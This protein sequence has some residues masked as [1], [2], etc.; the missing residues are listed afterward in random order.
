MKSLVAL[1]MRGFLMADASA[2]TAGSAR[3]RARRRPHRDFS[4]ERLED[5]TLMSANAAGWSEKPVAPPVPVAA[6]V[7]HTAVAQVA[8][9][10][11]VARPGATARNVAATRAT[12]TVPDV[13]D[14]GQ[15]AVFTVKLSQPAGPRGAS[16]AYT[17]RD[18]R[19]RAGVDYTATRGTVTFR[20]GETEKTVSVPT[21]AS[22]PV[23]AKAVNF[24]LVL[25]SASNA[26]ITVNTATTRI[27]DPL[28]VVPPP[29]FTI[30]VTFPDNSL[31]L[32]QQRVF[33]VAA[34]RWSEIITGDL[35]D[36]TWD[37]RTI[38]DIEIAA[39]AP[40]ID[41]VGS[42]LGQAAWS[43]LRPIPAGTPANAPNTQLPFL[44]FMRFDSADVSM[45]MGNGTF[46]SVVLHEMGHVLGI[47]SSLWSVKRLVTGLGTTN[48]VYTGPKALAEYNKLLSIPTATSVPLEN[49]GGGGTA[50]SHWRESIFDTELMTGYSEQGGIPMPISRVTVGAL[51]DLGYT[52]DYAKA[53]PFRLRANV[54]GT[55]PIRA[56]PPPSGY[57]GSWL[58]AG[59]TRPDLAWG[60]LT[61]NVG[62][63]A[64]KPRQAGWQRG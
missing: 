3:D 62:E 38:D 22:S 43:Q 41:G 15:P 27:T 36:M 45:M 37:G 34:Q 42:I 46:Q 24:R 47:S 63:A 49:T 4:C 64:V 56:V 9:S 21:L 20:A 32:S 2:G 23:Q 33:T 28:P 31:S 30:N 7:N 29:N 57:A 60:A 12:V 51:E 17:T 48:P 8:P 11:L 25:S 52:V 35:P 16:F 55:G 10:S 44:G 18:L 14:R 13:V 61:V 5:R 59:A 39:T 50:G 26:K 19:A 1:F 54:G 53:D 6:A 40:Y 58:V